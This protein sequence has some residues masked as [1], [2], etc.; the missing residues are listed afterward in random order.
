MI[1][2][3]KTSDQMYVCMYVFIVIT[4]SRVWVNRVYTYIN[5]H[6]GTPDKNKKQ[7]RNQKQCTAVENIIKHGNAC[8]VLQSSV[9]CINDDRTVISSTAV[10]HT[11]R[12]KVCVY[13]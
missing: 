11:L 3:T 4:Y 8:S 2:I 1:L 10:V 7:N 5:R 13:F 12:C 9:I 6:A